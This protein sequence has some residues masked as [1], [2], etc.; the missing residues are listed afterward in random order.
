MN[1]DFLLA[2]DQQ[3]Q[4]TECVCMLFTCAENISDLQKQKEESQKEIFRLFTSVPFEEI[5]AR[6]EAKVIESKHSY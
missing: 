5:V 6:S 1:C 3:C 2:R 4:S